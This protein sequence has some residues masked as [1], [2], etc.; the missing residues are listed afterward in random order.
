[1]QPKNLFFGGGA[2]ATLLHPLIAVWMVVAA[3]LILVLPRNKAIYPFLLA[4]FTIPFPQVVLIGPLHFPV[5][6]ILIMVGLV[7]RIL[8]LGAPAKDKFPGGFNK[9]DQAAILWCLSSFIVL[10]L[11]WMNM[12]G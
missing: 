12:A 2:S 9:I 11:Q 6:R 7:R 8:H 3:V 1:M 10:C 4:F 5:L